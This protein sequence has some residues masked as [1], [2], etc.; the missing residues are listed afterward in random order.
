MAEVKTTRN[1]E[2]GVNSWIHTKTGEDSASPIGWK[3]TGVRAFL[4]QLRLFNF[5]WRFEQRRA[6]RGFWVFEDFALEIPDDQP[7]S[8]AAQ[9]VLW[10]HRHFATAARGINDVLWDSVTGGMPA[11]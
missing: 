11:H 10:I 9:N 7:V 5:P 8:I 1:C 2:S 6:V 4:N 3:R